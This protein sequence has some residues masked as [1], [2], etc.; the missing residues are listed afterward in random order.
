MNLLQKCFVP[1]S[2]P[3]TVDWTRD[4]MIDV[5]PLLNPPPS[6]LQS[7]QCLMVHSN[8]P[9]FSLHITGYS[10]HYW[11]GWLLLSNGVSANLKIKFETESI[12][13]GWMTWGVNYILNLICSSR[14]NKKRLR[15]SRTEFR[16]LF[17]RHFGKLLLFFPAHSTQIISNLSLYYD[18]VK[19]GLFF[20]LPN[21]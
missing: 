3:I 16:I 13:T 6:I 5:Q 12:S 15:K 20:F 17:Q 14:F 9:T 19:W 18:S 7:C 1:Y 2:V 11:Q 4:R 8:K 10:S 21:I